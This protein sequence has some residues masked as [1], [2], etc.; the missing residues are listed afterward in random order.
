MQKNS[1]AQPGVETLPSRRHVQ[2]CL[3]LAAGLSVYV[4]G[5]LLWFL[6][7]P[8]GRYPLLDSAE[9]LTLARQIAEGTLPPIPFFRAMLYPA[10]L[11]IFLR[12]GVGTDWLPVVAGLF[13]C[14]CHLVSTFF[15]Y[16]IALRGWASPRAGL[17]AAV[18]FGFNPVAVYF[19]AEPLDTTFGLC[20]FLAGLNLLHRQWQMLQKAGA[21][22][23]GEQK[24]LCLDLAAVGALWAL[25]MLARPHYAI[26]LAGVILLLA[27]RLWRV[28]RI[29]VPSTGAFVLAAGCLLGLAGFWQQ[30]V[31]GEFRIMPTQGAYSLW[32]GNR[33]GANGRY[34]EQKI[35]LPAG[36][37]NEG[38]NPARIESHV[39]YQRETGNTNATTAQAEMN[40]W[41]QR[42]VDSIRA[43]PGTWLGLMAKKA[44]FALNDFEQYNNKT[45]AVQKAL[46]PV[47]KPNPLGWGVTLVLCAAGLVVMWRPDRRFRGGFLTAAVAALYAAGV[48]LFFVSDRFR[49]PLLPFLCVGAGC[50]GLASFH[51]VRQLLTA[52]IVPVGATVLAVA[53]IT[54]SRGFG[55]YDLAPAVQDYV[56][57]SIACGKAG[58]DLES[59]QWARKALASRPDHADAL[60]CAVNGFFNCQLRGVDPARVFSDETWDLQ[61]IRVARIPQPTPGLRL[62]NSV[63][64]WKTG[65]PEEA[66]NTLRALS[67]ATP[68]STN[69]AKAGA[70]DDALGVLL[71]TGLHEPLDEANARSRGG[72]TGS[73][74]LLAALARHEDPAHP[75]IPS[76]RRDLVAQLTPFVRQIFP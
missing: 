21:L 61:V 55:V 11:S 30:H 15:V 74:Y 56:A 9:N 22:N 36:E 13:G 50:W 31:T 26:V 76:N 47:L 48:I 75:L 27:A 59:L 38:D 62:V 69:A 8:L 40:Y 5:Y 16:R 34:F 1:L 43:N 39:L 12:L 52:R 19:A 51:R 42:T 60:A 37:T 66:R 20:L 6:G 29:L 70:T 54:F 64:L 49:L 58:N 53:A 73:F 17:W 72:D 2:F 63:A 67:Q 33:P 41:R 65:R 4:L 71:L 46:S 23:A 24:R 25:A 3:A 10:T 57:L 28:P 14:L 32:A 35:H 44:Y 18:L 7:S 45:Y 68:A